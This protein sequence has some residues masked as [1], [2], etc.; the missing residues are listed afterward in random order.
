MVELAIILPLLALLLVMALDFGRVFYSSV[1]LNNAS[2]VGA[3]YAAAHP[4]DTWGPGSRY[5]NQIQRDAAAIGCQLPTPLPPPTFLN[6]TTPGGDA[7]VRLTCT[8][9][10]IT[11]LANSIIGGPAALAATSSFPIRSGLLAGAPPPPPPAAC[12]LV[13][14]L[15]GSSVSA[16]RVTWSQAGFAAGTF[17]PATGN[18]AEPVNFQTTSPVSVPGDCLPVTTTVTVGSTAAPPP[19][20]GCRIVPQL[21]GL[22]G[23][24]ARAE[25]T[26]YGFAAGTFSPATGNDTSTVL[27]QTTNPAASP[28]GCISPTSSVTVT[29]GAAPP[30]PTCTVPGLSGVGANQATNQWTGAGFSGTLTI[31]RP[32][33]GNY[34]IKNQTIVGGQKVPCNSAMSVGG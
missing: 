22:S 20:P 34:Q 8:F 15:V 24:A 27:T 14:N 12:F 18:D 11:P 9:T 13:P 33:N 2:R 25:W 6:G 16:A 26:S 3:N 30:P 10:L 4:T 17:S 23:A 21:V 29:F 32:P 31:T 1:S 19:P 7:R 5:A 28:G